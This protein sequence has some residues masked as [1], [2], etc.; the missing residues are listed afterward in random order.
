[1]KSKTVTII[2]IVFFTL[3]NISYFIEKLPGLWDFSIAII[4]ILGFLLLSGIII[5]QSIH[6]LIEKFRNKSRIISTVI[7]IGTLTITGLFP[8]G[9]INYEDLEGEDLLIANLEGV[10]N[11]QTVIKIKKNN[12][13]IQTSLCFGVEKW[14]GTHQ[15]IGDTIKLNYRDTL[16]LGNYKFAYGLIKMTNNKEYIKIG[17]I[18]MFP[19]YTSTIS[20]PMNIYYYNK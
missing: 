9:I 10:A 17:Q 13:F 3:V 16:D 5:E 11:C 20:I 2:S 15:I 12:K 18:F 4:I 6:L 7:L 8:N 19:S 14:N 1:M